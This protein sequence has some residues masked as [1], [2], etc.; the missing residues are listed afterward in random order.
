[1]LVVVVLGHQQPV[2]EVIYIKTTT[3]SLMDTLD[4]DTMMMMTL[5]QHN[6]PPLCYKV[7]VC[8]NVIT[9]SC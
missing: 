2:V 5:Y 7:G 4:M 6:I 3:V 1:M 8:P 9:F